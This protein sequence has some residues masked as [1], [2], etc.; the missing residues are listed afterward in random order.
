VQQ[1][2]QQPYTYQ[3]TYQNPAQQP[4]P[5]TRPIGTIAK[6]KGVYINQGGTI[7]KAQEVYVNNPT[8]PANQISKIHQSVPTPQFNL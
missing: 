7:R 2:Y 6:A 8:A 3:Q 5:A 4:Y 1:P